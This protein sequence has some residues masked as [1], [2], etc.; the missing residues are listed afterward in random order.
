MKMRK[1]I[2]VLEKYSLETGMRST[3]REF[4]RHIEAPNWHP[5]GRRLLYNSEGKLYYFDLDSKESTL[6]PTGRCVFCNNDHV[7]SQDGKL[8]AI[9]SGTEDHRA[10]RVW[11]L[12]SSGGEP[13]LMTEA[14]PSYLHGISPDGGTLAYCAERNGEYDVYTIKNEPGAREERL[15]AAPGLDDGPEYS[16]DGHY[17]WFNSVRSGLMQ[18]WRMRSDGREQTQMTFDEGR[19]SWFPHVSPDGQSVVYIA[20]KKGDVKPGDHPANREV[21]LRLMDATG[22][23][24]RTIVRLFGGQGTLNVN[25]WS[26]DSR[27]FAFVSYRFE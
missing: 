26:P 12:P 8:L 15:T 5:D 16:P 21:E 14:S 10:S 17:I 7:L 27:E 1:M 20:Y 3:L 23:P 18:I 11:L 22:S 24:A 4:D 25:S 13:Q 6:I 19:N 9:S 2:S